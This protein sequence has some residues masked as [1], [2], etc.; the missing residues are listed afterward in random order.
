[1]RGEVA[2]R[3][4]LLAQ[5]EEVSEPSSNG[6]RIALSLSVPPDLAEYDLTEADMALLVA[7][8]VRAVTITGATLFYCP[9]LPL[10]GLS[11][12]VIEQCV[13]TG[14]DERPLRLFIPEIEFER[15]PLSALRALAK[16]IEHVGGL[17]LVTSSGHPFTLDES[18]PEPDDRPIPAALTAL[19]AHVSKLAD[20]RIAIGGA[21]AAT[22]DEEPGI[23]EECRLTLENG[24]VVI[25]LG[26]YG[27]VTAQICEALYPS[28]SAGREQAPWTVRLR[29]LS[30]RQE[31]SRFIDESTRI[32]CATGTDPQALAEAVVGVIHS[33]RGRHH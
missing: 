33:V 5:R 6:V 3:P 21:P 12:L 26:G 7:A 17:S 10:S 32:L 30:D 2:E 28:R 15:Q 27:G 13:A 1:M 19:R 16:E 25:P 31:T 4:D 9:R 8:V 24:G 11:R 29:R 20:I 23:V 14:A 22:P 18:L